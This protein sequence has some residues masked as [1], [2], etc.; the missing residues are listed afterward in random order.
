MTNAEH[1][2]NILDNFFG[3]LDDNLGDMPVGKQADIIFASLVNMFSI[4]A[5]N[6]SANATSFELLRKAYIQHIE[7]TNYIH[8]A[9][10]LAKMALN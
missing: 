3:H 6:V 2:E 10:E 9:D 1:I 4:V 8:N 7:S 5:N